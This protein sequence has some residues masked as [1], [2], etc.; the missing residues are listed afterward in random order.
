[1]RTGRSSNSAPGRLLGGSSNRFTS[2]T[3]TDDAIRS[4]TVPASTQAPVRDQIRLRGTLDRGGP[5]RTE[6]A[7]S[8]RGAAAGRPR[9]SVSLTW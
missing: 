8:T 5:R 9:A 3:I 4:P 2:G 1:M 7:R 6:V